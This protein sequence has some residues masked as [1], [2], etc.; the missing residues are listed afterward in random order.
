MRG[1]FRQLRDYDGYDD[2]RRRRDKKKKEIPPSA[3]GE[4]LGTIAARKLLDEYVP[5]PEVVARQLNFKTQQG[6]D[7]IAD[8][9]E[10]YKLARNLQK[11]MHPT[12]LNY[13]SPF[14]IIPHPP[15]SPSV[16]FIHP[17]INSVPPPPSLPFPLVSLKGLNIP[18]QKVPTNR[19]RKRP[20]I[21]HSSSFPP[22]KRQQSEQQQVQT[23]TTHPSPKQQS[24]KDPSA[25]VKKLEDE[26][27]IPDL[28]FT[29]DPESDSDTDGVTIS[30]TTT[31]PAANHNSNQKNLPTT[32]SSS[33]PITQ[34]TNKSSS[35]SS[36][37]SAPAAVEAAAGTAKKKFS[38]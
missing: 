32:L 7:K 31:S 24:K 25:H 35:I 23:P 9:E 6:L 1:L 12:P 38:G 28:E 16:T 20:S 36:I 2:D 8:E 18:D 27:E 21:S 10:Q 4:V 37:S 14:G 22:P 15:K 11:N 29:T 17:D 26:E 30:T 33:N 19:N 3:L 34:Q 13:P 5:T